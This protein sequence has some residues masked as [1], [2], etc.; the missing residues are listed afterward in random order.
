MGALRTSQ[1]EAM[2]EADRGIAELE[3]QYQAN[4][5]SA[6]ADNDYQ[7]AQALMNEYNNGY[8]RDPTEISAATQGCTARRRQTAW[9][10]S[11]KARTRSL[12]I[13]PG[14]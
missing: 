10:P 7:R 6:I 12:R 11:G 9:R 1:A 4:V 3:R 5:S 13:I 2:A 14:G 8:S